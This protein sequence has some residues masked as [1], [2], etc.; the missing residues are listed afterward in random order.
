MASRGR[1]STRRCRSNAF[2]ASTTS[3]SCHAR[4]SV[5]SSG[6]AEGDPMHIDH[7]VVTVPNLD[8]AARSY[9]S[10]GFTLTPRAQHPWGTANRLVQLAGR[11]FIE[12]LEID[13]PHLIGEHGSAADPPTFSFGAFNRD[14]LASGRQGFSML[15]LE[16]KSVHADLA[17]YHVAGLQPYAPFHFERQ[18]TL[19]DG[20]TVKV[21]FDLAFAATPDMPDAGF[22]TCHNRFPENFWKPEFQRHANGASLIREAVAFHP[23][24]HDLA[25]F[26]AGF[27]GT[28]SKE[29][30]GGIRVSG[31]STAVT[32][33]TP[34]AFK[35]RFPDSG[36]DVDARPRLALAVMAAGNPPARMTPAASAHGLA[37]AWAQAD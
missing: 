29:V 28:P 26:L 7:I 36:V 33:L 14:F 10:L 35:S 21:A 16:G 1:S 12:L 23:R 27:T 11:N 20:R 9:E 3:S 2:G 17:R 30:E 19:P 18:A 31:A 25:P 8:D 37:I 34:S 22:F 13:R 6:Q 24:P 4:A 5:S 15:V 32:V